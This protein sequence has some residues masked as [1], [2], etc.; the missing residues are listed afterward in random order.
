M[1][2]AGALRRARHGQGLGRHQHVPDLDRADPVGLITTQ[3]AV[4]PLVAELIDHVRL[5]VAVSLARRPLGPNVTP[6][7]DPKPLMLNDELSAGRVRTVAPLALTD[8]P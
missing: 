8:Q 2:V 4:T 1:P 3:R 5:A 7:P 6:A